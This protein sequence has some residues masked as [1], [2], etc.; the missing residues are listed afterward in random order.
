VTR[1]RPIQWVVL[2]LGAL[3]MVGSLLVAEEYIL[4]A[5]VG[6][7][8]VT[9]LAYWQL[10]G[11]S[12]PRRG[13]ATLPPAPRDEAVDLQTLPLRSLGSDVPIVATATAPPKVGPIGVARWLGLLVVG[14]LV[15]GPIATFAQIAETAKTAVR[16]SDAAWGA[17]LGSLACGW[18]VYAGLALSSR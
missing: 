16:F 12:R 4:R 8:L 5:L 10:Q 7:G 18:G 3:W 14:F 17:V 1:P 11:H 13:D 6:G 2:W 9:A 15:L